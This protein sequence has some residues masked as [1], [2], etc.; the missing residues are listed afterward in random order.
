MA[1]KSLCRKRLK[2]VKDS[3][4]E[5]KRS[6]GCIEWGLV[7]FIYLFGS[8]SGSSMDTYQIRSIYIEICSRE[9]LGSRCLVHVW[10]MN[11]PA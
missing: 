8:G 9:P 7:Q 10:Y 1:W 6:L 5:S 2:C 11:F 4:I 3:S